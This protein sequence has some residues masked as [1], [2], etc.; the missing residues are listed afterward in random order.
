M[1]EAELGAQAATTRSE[2]DLCRHPLIQE[3]RAPPQGA[4]QDGAADEVGPVE[5]DLLG[6]ERAH[7]EPDEGDRRLACAL[8]QPDAVGAV[9]LD[10][11][12]RRSQTGRLA[13]AAGIV[14]RV[15]EPLLE[16]GDLE[17]VPLASEPSSA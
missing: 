16:V 9:V 3:A 11:P 7:R 5:G 1:R 8:D 17:L 15:S 10:R 2:V 14:G 13:D 6:D 12:R 4:E